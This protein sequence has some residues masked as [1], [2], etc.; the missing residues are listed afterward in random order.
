MKFSEIFSFIIIHF[1]TK[2]DEFL[3]DF[4][5]IFFHESHI[6]PRKLKKKNFGKYSHSDSIFG[7]KSFKNKA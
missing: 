7:T 2:N 3:T 4:K 1:C 6:L 5:E